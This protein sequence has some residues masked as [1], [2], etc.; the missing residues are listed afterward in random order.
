MELP[1][2]ENTEG[3]GVGGKK[4]NLL[5]YLVENP[6]EKWANIILEEPR[7]EEKPEQFWGPGCQDRGRDLEPVGRV[8]DVCQK[9]LQ[10]RL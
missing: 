6:V 4:M 10:V 8:R 2:A 7:T 5:A 3:L 1:E 9:D